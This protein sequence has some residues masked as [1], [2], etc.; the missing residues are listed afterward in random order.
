MFGQRKG[1]RKERC[2]MGHKRKEKIN[3]QRWGRE[4]K[5]KIPQSH[6]IGMARQQLELDVA[7][8]EVT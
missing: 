4:L 2:R 8:D 6:K 1:I 5:S 3:F 7:P